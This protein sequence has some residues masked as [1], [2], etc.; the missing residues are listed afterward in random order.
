MRAPRV[1][2]AFPNLGSTGYRVASPG[3]LRYNC[4]AWA[5][6]DVTRWWWPVGDY[7]P[8]GVP[9]VVDLSAFTRAYGALGYEPCEDGELGSGFEKIAIYAKGNGVPTHAA[10]QLEDGRWSSKLGKLED[11]A[12]SLEGLA[13]CLYGQIVLFMKRPAGD[14]PNP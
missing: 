4:I 11:I 8:P 3:D 1:E 5:A 12:H 6:E 13:E 14:R 7:W 2:R 9:R 10:R